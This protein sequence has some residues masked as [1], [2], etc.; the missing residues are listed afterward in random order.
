MSAPVSPPSAPV[1][2]DP[3]PT[4]VQRLVAASGITFAVLLIA[5]IIVTGEETPD[6]GAALAEWTEFARDNED[7]LRIGALIF[8]LATYQFL[9]FIGYLRSVLG[10]AEH[11]V[12][13]FTRGSYMVLAAG[14]AGIAGMAMGIFI[15]AAGTDPDYPPEILRALNELG[16]A[17]FGLAAGAFGACFVT[18]GLVNGAVRA[19]PAWLGYVALG[20]GI[21][22]VLQLGILLSEDE[23]NFFGIFFPIG[24]L[25]LVIFCAG[26]SVTF[27]R[28]P[29]PAR[30]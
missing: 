11:A 1:P 20:C 7:G 17:G 26:A 18:V 23:D 27:L 21:S 13:G 29:A 19:L 28:G 12:R 6:D 25:L 4:L 9:L 2:A 8:A 10:A 5:T 22:F 16:G 15:S 14:T 3:V 24:F 30:T